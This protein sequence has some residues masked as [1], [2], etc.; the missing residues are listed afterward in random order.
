MAGAS[1]KLNETI[2]RSQLEPGRAALDQPHQAA[3]QLALQRAVGAVGVDCRAIRRPPHRAPRDRAAWRR[4]G[5]PAAPPRPGRWPS[6]PAARRRAGAARFST[7]ADA[8]AGIAFDDR[9]GARRPRGRNWRPT[10]RTWRPWSRRVE[11]EVGGGVVDMQ[12]RVAAR[13]AHR[14]FHVLPAPAGEA[15]VEGLGLEHVAADQQVGGEDVLFRLGRR[16]AA[17]AQSV[18]SAMPRWRAWARVRGAWSQREAAEGDG[19]GLG[20]DQLQL[21]ARNSGR[22]RQHVGVEEQE[23][24]A[25]GVGWP[26]GCGPGAADVG[27]QAHEAGRQASGARPSSA[28]LGGQR[29]SSRA[30]VQHDDLD[31]SPRTPR[32]RARPAARRGPRAGTGSAP[33]PSARRRPRRPIV[34]RCLAQ[35]VSCPTSAQGPDQADR[36]GAHAADVQDVGEDGVDHDARRRLGA[37]LPARPPLAGTA[38]TA[39][40]MHRRGDSR[41]GQPYQGTGRASA[42]RPEAERGDRAQG[43]ADQGRPQGALQAEARD[44]RPGTGRCC[45]APGWPWPASNRPVRRARVKAVWK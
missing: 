1:S 10:A 4:R 24:V 27:G 11:A 6:A 22:V 14:P 39:R 43:V 37:Q 29:R 26:A 25:A 28:R 36:L 34:E 8:I 44:Q 30:V 45:S 13:D 16:A 40:A 23:P 12:D 5:R 42:R 3:A 35:A 18:R 33:T 7:R 21:A 20:V 31:A 19:R 2:G 38:A 15:G 17:G 9:R 32:G 41:P